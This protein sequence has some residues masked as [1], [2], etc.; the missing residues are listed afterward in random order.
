MNT[1]VDFYNPIACIIQNDDGVAYDLLSVDVASGVVTSALLTAKACA[2][3][4]EIVQRA[5]NLLPGLG[6]VALQAL[7]TNLVALNQ[8]EG[9]FVSAVNVVGNAY[10]LNLSGLANPSTMQVTLPMSTSSPFA[11]SGGGGNPAA[12]VVSPALFGFG[13]NGG[14]GAN[15]TLFMFPWY[16]SAAM[17]NIE[18]AIPVPYDGVISRLF[19]H[20]LAATPI[21]AGQMVITVR[22]NNADTALAIAWVNNQQDMSNVVDSFPV[23][24][25]DI[26]SMK[27]ACSADFAGNSFANCCAVMQLAK[28]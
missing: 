27:I 21:V 10:T 28:T 13:T 18:R 20:A 11:G 8:L 3:L 22:K 23:V 1:R 19:F 14:P 4:T 16:E 24:A 17:D 25:G 2:F 9:S 6:Q 5:L 7:V 15:Q 12:T 26:L